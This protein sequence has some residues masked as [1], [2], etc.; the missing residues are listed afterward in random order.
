[1]N[2]TVAVLGPGR[3]GRQIGLAFALGGWRVLMVDLKERPAGEARSVFADC[4][5]E[6]ARDVRL[7]TEEEVIAAADGRDALERIEDHVGLAGI[8]ECSF[9]QEALPESFALKREVLGRL[10]GKVKPEA[11]VASTSSTIS[12]SYLVDAVDGPDR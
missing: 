2:E 12:P 4:R 8:G 7:M 6:I 11:I 3:I 5:R 1:M 10:A 9:I